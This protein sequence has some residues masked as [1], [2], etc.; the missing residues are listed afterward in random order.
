MIWSLIYRKFKGNR[1]NTMIALYESDYLSNLIRQKNQN[2]NLIDS[3]GYSFDYKKQCI[4][5][6][7]ANYKYMG[8]QELINIY[9]KMHQK[10]LRN[11]QFE[12]HLQAFILQNIN[13]VLDK[14]LQCSYKLEWLGNEVGCGVGMQRID[15][16]ASVIVNNERVV[17]PIELKSHN[18]DCNILTQIQR[19]IDWLNCYYLRVNETNKILQVILYRDTNYNIRNNQL[20][21]QY[22]SY[23]NQYNSYTC[24]PLKHIKFNFKNNEIIFA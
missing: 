7:N 20:F 11:N 5:P 8:K 2:W 6:S 15:I 4:I 17:I 14:I 22:E 21:S 12:T 1:G 3:N 10:F 19:Y 9:P 23:F 24:C 18:A 13:V 16:M